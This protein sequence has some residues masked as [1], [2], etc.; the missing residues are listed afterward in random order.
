MKVFK[1]SRPLWKLKLKILINSF[2]LFQ[3]YLEEY[4]MHLLS[5]FK[6]ISIRIQ[7]IEKILYLILL[8]QW[9]KFLL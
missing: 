1:N 3:I 6:K 4:Q 5:S 8:K 7:K 2:K 9:D